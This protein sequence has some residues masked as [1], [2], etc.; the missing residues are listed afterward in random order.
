MK[1]LIKI[2]TITLFLTSSFSAISE[3]KKKSNQLII[4]ADSSIEYFEDKQTYI[5][6]GNAK[7]YKDNFILKGDIIKALMIQ[8]NKNQK[9]QRIFAR[10][11]VFINKDKEVAQAEIADYDFES[12]IITLKGKYQSFKNSKI[13]IESSKI[14]RFNDTTKKAY[15]LGNVKL[16]LENS[17]KII[18]NKLEAKFT[19]IDNAII[20]AKATGEVKIL[21]KLET[22]LCNS[23]KFENNKGII[24]LAGDVQIKKGDSIIT[25]EKGLINLKTGKSKIFSKKSKRVKGVFS[26]SK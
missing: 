5:A 10:G 14:I 13:K 21:T 22:I 2:F 15:S 12:N 20:D 3:S 17:I 4:E 25:G 24:S 8:K 7:A 6:T 23:A 26:P 16:N 19:K 11:N 1:N 9:I 18:S